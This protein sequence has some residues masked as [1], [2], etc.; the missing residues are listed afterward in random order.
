MGRTPRVGFGTD[1]PTRRDPGLIRVGRG[2]IGGTFHVKRPAALDR[3]A[4]SALGSSQL[5]GA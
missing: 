1:G 5:D 4:A 3:S 2:S